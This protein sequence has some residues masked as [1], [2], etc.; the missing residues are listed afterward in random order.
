VAAVELWTLGLPLPR[1]AALQ[2]ERAEV[3]PNRDG[4]GAAP[5]ARRCFL[6]E[7]APEVRAG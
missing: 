2:A 3:G 1:Y 4:G 6:E 7:V 5:E